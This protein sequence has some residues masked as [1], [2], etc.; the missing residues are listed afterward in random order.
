[1]NIILCGYKSSGKTTLGKALAQELVYDFIDIDQLMLKKA[2]VNH[3]NNT[4]IGQ[5]FTQLGESEFRQL[6]ERVV[7]NFSPTKKTIIATGGGTVMNPNNVTHL[8]SLGKLVYLTIDAKVLYQRLSGSKTPSF[9]QQ[10]NTE[11]ALKDY[12]SSRDVIY[13]RA[14]DVSIDMT[15]K[16]IEQGID[17]IKEYTHENNLL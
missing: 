17:L 1:M 6:E 5:L 14:A 4:S 16:S 3:V 2:N 13:K 9:I 7:H 15:G 11:E 12:L 8:K 10:N